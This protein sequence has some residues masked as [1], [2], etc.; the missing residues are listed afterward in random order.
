MRRRL[1]STISA[2]GAIILLVVGANVSFFWIVDHAVEADAR[3]KSER[4]VHLL[5]EQVPAF[6]D[7]LLSGKPS[8]T[9]LAIMQELLHETDTFRFSIY[10]ADGRQSA[11]F[12][13]N[14]IVSP[15][16]DAPPSKEEWARAR[17]GE[18]V[19]TLGNQVSARTHPS[20]YAVIIRTL[21]VSENDDATI[22]K[23]FIDQGGFATTLKDQSQKLSIALTL[24]FTAMLTF[25]LV[26]MLRSNRREEV[27]HE[28]LNFLARHDPLT[29]LYNRNGFND[30]W[31]D[32]PKE[33]GSALLFID[34][35]HFKQI[36]DAYSHSTGDAFIKHV[37]NMIANSLG[38]QDFAGRLGG[39][40]FA[41]AM[42]CNTIEAA[43]KMAAKLCTLATKPAMV[44]GIHITGSLS[45]GIHFSAGN[46]PSL[47][48]RMKMADFALYQAKTSGRS[49]YRNFSAELAT[50][51]Q[52]RKKIE[53]ALTRALANDYF[54]LTYQPL[55]SAQTLECIAFEALLR[56]K[57]PHGEIISPAEFIPLVEEMG[58]AEKVGEWVL[59]NAALAAKQW[60]DD[61]AVSVNLSAR[62]FNTDALVDTVSTI[63]AQVGLPASRLVL[64]VTESQL[65]EAPEA[66]ERELAQLRKLGV[67]ISIDDFGTGYSSLGYLWRFGFDK[68][69]IDR[70]FV[71]GMME[72][73]ARTIKILDSMILLSHRLGIPVI[74]E[75]VETA[76]QVE[77]LKDLGVDNFQG[78]Y[79]GRPMV[80]SDLPA[81]FEK[82]RSG[83]QSRTSNP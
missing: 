83:R 71:I 59:R 35:D 74:V 78:F 39:D 68:I 61:I 32:I 58:L 48:D 55:V 79:F 6:G 63:L 76:E 36:N 53:N 70:S 72:N 21:N 34:I 7:A 56:M 23:I 65:I 44:Q 28:R 33:A 54:Y 69:K 50:K 62:Q 2:F 37:G 12:D 20:S 4:W 16:T 49:T 18:Q 47:E 17:A 25:F 3:L 22:G 64:E 30:A 75:G 24:L 73:R 15:S 51:A 80:K 43:E 27:S 60:S 26:R 66:A 1:I 45:I 13:E 31:R 10:S 52:R 82:M 19:I 29:S 40:E 14:G 46:A 38:P 41:L 11:T 57:L 42:R 67:S 8:P 81:Y 5:Q 9:Q 77:I